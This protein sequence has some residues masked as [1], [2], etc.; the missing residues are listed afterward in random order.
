MNMWN[1]IS[2]PPA[3]VHLHGVVLNSAVLS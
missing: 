2:T 1:Y 3:L